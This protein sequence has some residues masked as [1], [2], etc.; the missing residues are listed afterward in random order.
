MEKTELLFEELR[1]HLE[2]W[3]SNVSD[4][5]RGKAK[6]TEHE[7]ADYEILAK[8]LNSEESLQAFEHVAYWAHLRAIGMVLLMLDGVT[9]L[10]SHFNVALIDRET[11]ED[12][13]PPGS[14]YDSDFMY[15]LHTHG[16]VTY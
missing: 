2:Y 3:T 14:T 12:L 11:K 1:G 7:R 10:A 9:H 4:I 8:H 6:P 13:A 16:H 15:Y 5:I